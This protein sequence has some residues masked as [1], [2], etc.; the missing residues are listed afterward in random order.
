MARTRRICRRL[1][2]REPVPLLSSRRCSPLAG[3]RADPR[4]GVRLAGGLAL[5]LCP[6]AAQGISISPGRSPVPPPGS[7]SDL[8]GV[9]EDSCR[10]FWNVTSRERSERKPHVLPSFHPEYVWVPPRGCEY[11]PGSSLGFDGP[12]AHL[13]AV[14]VCSSAHRPEAHGLLWTELILWDPVLRD[15]VSVPLG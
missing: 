15:D 13:P 1:A 5:G 9:T 2:S 4:A 3:T 12:P 7:S 14:G 11:R 8:L 10:W 6:S